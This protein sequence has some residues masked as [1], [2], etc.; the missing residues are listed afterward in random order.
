MTTVRITDAGGKKPTFVQ[1]D[2][3][4]VLYVSGVASQPCLHFANAE[5]KRAIVVQATYDNGRWKCLVPNF[6]L[7]FA[8][9]MVVSVFV[10][11]DEG[12]TVATAVYEVKPKL[13]PQDYSYTENIGYINWVAKS[14]EVQ[15][16]IDEIQNK[17]D[18]GTLVGGPFWATYGITTSSEIET[19]YQAGRLCLCKY[20]I[21]G[22]DYIC[23]LSARGS[24]ELHVFTATDGAQIVVLTCFSDSWV[25]ES[26]VL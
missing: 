22:N 23:R 10:Q 18:N 14:E 13:K 1:W 17:L 20:Q 2:V 15:D 21:N 4:R 26:A 12:R 5:L 9:P 19:A 3:D 8:C 7:Q 16:L 6:I 25:H 11:P 24:S